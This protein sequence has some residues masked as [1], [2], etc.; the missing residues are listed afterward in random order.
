VVALAPL[1]DLRRAATGSSEVVRLM[2]GS[3]GER[4]D[5]YDAASPLD[6]L[7]IGVRQLVVHGTDDRTVPVAR[8]RTYVARAQELGDPAELCEV[9]GGH[10]DVLR[11]RSAGWRAATRFVA[12]IVHSGGPRADQ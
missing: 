11:A 7:P 1:T 10:R 2:G 8:S 4:A 3:P 9:A 6:R 5:A 12:E